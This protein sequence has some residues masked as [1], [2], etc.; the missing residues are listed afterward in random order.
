[1]LVKNEEFFMEV[2]GTILKN[3]SALAL[4]HKPSLTTQ[5]L[6]T[7]QAKLKCKV[8]N[9][10]PVHTEFAVYMECDPKEREIIVNS[11][12]YMDRF[13]FLW[14]EGLITCPPA[15]FAVGCCIQT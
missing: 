1:M 4:P 8:S 7:I 15:S 12:V 3:I 6:L 14:T 2:F 13:L 11:A 9:D 10:L 5:E